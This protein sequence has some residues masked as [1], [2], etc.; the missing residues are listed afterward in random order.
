MI[1]IIYEITTTTTTTTKSIAFKRKL[2]HRRLLFA[3][4]RVLELLAIV[5]RLRNGIYV[6]SEAGN[7]KATCTGKRWVVCYSQRSTNVIVILAFWILD[8]IG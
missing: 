1:V 7:N 8:K 6:E 2:G 3:S 4:P 5:V